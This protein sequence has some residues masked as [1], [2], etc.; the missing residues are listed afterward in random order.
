V[1]VSV[2]LVNKRV[3]VVNLIQGDLST[4]G[5]VKTIVYT[6]NNKILSFLT[7]LNI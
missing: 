7:S 5:R 6:V 4:K 3:K 1:F 2:D